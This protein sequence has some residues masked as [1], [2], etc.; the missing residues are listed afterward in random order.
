MRVYTRDD[1]MPILKWEK[2]FEL[3]V[4]P[5]DEQH[6]QLVG[7][8]NDLYDI[9]NDGDATGGAFEAVIAELV[10]YTSYHFAAEEKSMAFHEHD[11]LASHKEEHAKF[12]Q[13]VA[14]FQSEA[15][16]GRSDV[17]FDVLSFLG[18]WLFDHILVVDSEY[19]KLVEHQ[20]R[21]D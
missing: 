20:K 17:A 16:D 7:L 2:R 19:V 21:P 9:I 11:G 8:L 10:N 13:M 14:T 15:H 5:F 18:N 12:C 4:E 1:N 3:G 6:K